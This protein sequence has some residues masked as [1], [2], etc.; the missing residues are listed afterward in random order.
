MIN[1]LFENAPVVIFAYNRPEKLNALLKSLEKNKEFEDTEVIFYIDNVKFQSDK[2][3]H[4][5]VINVASKEWRCRS[6]KINVNPSN[7]GLKKNILSGIDKTFEVYDT[8][9]F[10]EDDLIVS[11][12]FLYFMNKSLSEYKNIPEVMH[13]SGYNYPFLFSKKSKSYFSTVMNCWGW[14]TWKDRWIENNNFSKNLIS[15]LENKK[16]RR[17]NVFGFEKDF[18]SQLIRNEIKELETWAIYWYQ[19]IFLNGGLCVQ[20]LKSLVQN[21]GMDGSGERK[22]RSNFYKSKLNNSRISTYPKN[23]KFLN[24]HKAQLIIFF[25][26]KTFK[27]NYFKA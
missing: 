14:S 5:E 12:S 21:K 17:F 13:I 9:I 4:K 19:Y 24:S 2:K 26:Y 10:L 23:I 16:R 15:S 22:I 8:G 7:I 25:I 18:E 1:N 6:K 27:K 20:P 11:E 3:L